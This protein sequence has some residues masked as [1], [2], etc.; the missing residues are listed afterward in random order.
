VRPT[1]TRSL[2]LRAVPDGVQ[3]A[4][5]AIAMLDL[6]P[7]ELLEVLTDDPHALRDFSVWCRANSHQLVEHDRRDGADHLVIQR[8][9]DGPPAVFT[10]AELDGLPGPVRR[11]LRAA[12]APGTPLGSAARLRMHGHIKVGRWLPFH[13]QQ[14]LDP[15]HGFQ[16]N[17]RAAGVVT[18]FDRYANGRGQM[19]WRLLGMLPLM[20]A[21]GPDVSRS[22]AG[23]AAAEALWVPTALLPRF[24]V[25]WSAADDHHL[26]A[27]YRIDTV[28]VEVYYTLDRDGHLRSVVFDRWGDPD[29]TG[30][31]GVHPFGGELTSYA[32]FDGLSIPNAGRFGWFFG[33]DRW[34]QGEFFR[35]QITDL[36]LIDQHSCPR[37]P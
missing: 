19:R 14:T 20:R 25:D 22:A 9:A 31:W 3:L 27:R 12:I 10:E 17:A 18:G 29:G 1:I 32:T 8:Q 2:D 15:H 5:A 23:R 34:S 11:Y 37:I 24:G 33:T 13:A 36:Q 35:Y 26:T 6:R 7:G 28:Q 30:T 21:D 16:W 4:T